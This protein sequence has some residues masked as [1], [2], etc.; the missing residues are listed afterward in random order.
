LRLLDNRDFTLKK[1]E[2][3]CEAVAASKYTNVTF[4]EYLNH[5]AENTTHFIILRHD[6]DVNAKNALD[7]AQV[8]YQYGLRATYYF[9]TIKRVFVPTIMDRIASYNHEIGYHYETLDRSKRNLELAVKLFQQELAMFRQRYEIKTVCMH[10]TSLTKYDNK[11]IWK[12]HK[13][14]D[15]D[16]LG[17]P[18][19]SIDYAKFAYFSDSSRTWSSDKKT[20]DKVDAPSQ[21]I[22]PRNTDELIKI[23]EGGERENIC[24]LTHP[25]RWSA[26]LRDYLSRYAIDLV[27]NIGK[28]GIG[29]QRKLS[30]S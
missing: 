6:I 8:E 20:K 23:V 24:V 11:E 9:R 30:R 4:E 15:F 28:T 27:Y 22:Q 13:L 5:H 2:Q 1:Y 29:W 16:L 25:I 3:L 7:M 18:Y 12:E 21:L 17:E 19:L 10:G 14:S 26:N